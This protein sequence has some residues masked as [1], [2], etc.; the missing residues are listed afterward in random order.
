MQVVFRNTL[1][2]SNLT[3][4]QLRVHLNSW[5]SFRHHSLR[6]GVSICNQIQIPLEIQILL[7]IQIQR[8]IDVM[9]SPILIFTRNTNHRVHSPT[10]HAGNK[11]SRQK[12]RIFTVKLTPPPPLRSAW[13]Q[14]YRFFNNFPNLIFGNC[15]ILIIC[16]YNVQCTCTCTLYLVPGTC[17]LYLVH[18]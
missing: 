15:W 6:G 16:R 14:V 11:G 13:P 4:L 9:V 7:E 1:Q 10:V 8:P 12:I 2:C 3:I 18:V 17:T 5:K